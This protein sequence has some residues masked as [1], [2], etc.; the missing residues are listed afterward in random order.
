MGGDGED[1]EDGEM[2]R[3]AKIL[4]SFCVRIQLMCSTF[5]PRLLNPFFAFP[6][7]PAPLLPRSPAPPLLLLGEQGLDLS[8]E[9]LMIDDRFGNVTVSTTLIE[10]GFAIA[11]HRVSCHQNNR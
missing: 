10:K 11:S 6:F 8:D 1:G 3:M 9:I 7:S 4:L 2:R 5:S